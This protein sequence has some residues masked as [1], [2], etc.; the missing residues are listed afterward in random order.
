MV[1]VGTAVAGIGGESPGGPVDVVFVISGVLAMRAAGLP[2]APADIVVFRS[3]T[4]LRVTGDNDAGR[5][6]TVT[7]EAP[8]GLGGGDVGERT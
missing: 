3:G 5:R 6:R 4:R 1:E 8:S 2:G 7:M